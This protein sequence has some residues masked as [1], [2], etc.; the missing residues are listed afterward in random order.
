MIFQTRSKLPHSQCVGRYSAGLWNRFCWD[1]TAPRN[2]T[3]YG[4]R[5]NA[6]TMAPPNIS[7]AGRTGD[8]TRPTACPNRWPGPGSPRTAGVARGLSATSG[9]AGADAPPETSVPLNTRVTPGTSAPELAAEVIAAPVA[10]GASTAR[11]RR[12]TNP[13]PARP[14]RPEPDSSPEFQRTRR[15]NTVTAMSR[16]STLITDIAAA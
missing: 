9:A 3:T 10:R 7:P 12:R 1:L 4:A 2:I 6:A 5:K 13:E 16:N 8:H 15:R 11:T 14:A